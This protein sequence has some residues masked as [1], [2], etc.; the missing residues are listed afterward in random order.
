MFCSIETMSVISSQAS[1]NDVISRW[2]FQSYKSLL[3]EFE[4]SKGAIRIRKFKKD[5]Q[6]HSQLN[7][8][9]TKWQN[10][11]PQNT[12]QK[13]KKRTTQTALKIGMSSVA[14][15][16]TMNA[17]SERCKIVRQK[18]S[19]LDKKKSKIVIYGDKTNTNQ[20]QHTENYKCAMQA[21]SVASYTRKTRQNE[22]K[23]VHVYTY[24]DSSMVWQYIMAHLN[25]YSE[26]LSN[27]GSL[28]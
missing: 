3:E 7:E 24:P 18:I 13:T 21:P 8:K 19:R 15:E 2:E 20:R 26:T 17:N 27:K 1:Y 14:P 6:H 11:N 5:R 10:N 12:R 22:A 28:L 23:T 4:D 9:Q 25:S 16:G